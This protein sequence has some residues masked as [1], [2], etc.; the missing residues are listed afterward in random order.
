MIP[1]SAP[2]NNARSGIDRLHPHRCVHFPLVAPEAGDLH[3]EEFHGCVAVDADAREAEWIRIAV[4][5]P[6]ERG[7]R[8]AITSLSNQVD[9]QMAEIT[10]AAIGKAKV[11]HP[12][13]ELLFNAPLGLEDLESSF[14]IAAH[15]P[16][17]FVIDR[18][19][20]EGK[21]HGL[22]ATRFGPG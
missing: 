4:A 6:D 15:R 3:P 21:S 20:A 14:V 16:E 2:A 1:H 5:Q 18:M 10:D 19:R 22:H 17:N 12:R 13:L 11:I 7:C 8:R 9:I